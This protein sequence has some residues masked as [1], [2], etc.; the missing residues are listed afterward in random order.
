MTA[1]Q[2]TVIR[3]LLGYK[4][5]VASNRMGCCALIR[6]LYFSVTKEDNLYSDINRW[7]YEFDDTNN[8]LKRHQVR[9]YSYSPTD[10]PSHG[11]YDVYSDSTHE[12]IIYEYLT[13]KS[14]HILTDYYDY[15]TIVMDVPRAINL[16]S[17]DVL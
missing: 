5:E 8:L 16:Q 14:G 15:G 6:N 10:V 13:D 4:D 9:I 2:V 17:E 7:R 11:N 12:S 1:N 3:N